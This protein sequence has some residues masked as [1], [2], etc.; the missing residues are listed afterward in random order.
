MRAP[1]HT[2]A[3]NWPFGS[4]TI[5]RRAAFACRVVFFAR[6]ARE[7]WLAGKERGR[8]TA[9]R[10]DEHSARSR[11]YS[12]HVCTAPSRGKQ[13]HNNAERNNTKGTSTLLSC[14]MYRAP[15]SV[16]VLRSHDTISSQHRMSPRL[17][18]NSDPFHDLEIFWHNAGPA[19]LGGDRYN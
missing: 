9:R 17:S 18:Q 4:G 6:S 19:P 8:R 1:T 5:Q 13:N 14:P 16:R 2:P 10:S 12:T 15:R 7:R 3:C 11:C